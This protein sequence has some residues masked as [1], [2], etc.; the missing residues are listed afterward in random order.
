MYRMY[1]FIERVCD[2]LDENRPTRVFCFTL[3]NL[4]VHA[5]VF[6]LNLITSRGHRYLF[7]APYW[8]VDGPMEYVFNTFHVKLLLFFREIEDLDELRN[9]LNQIIA[10]LSPNGF[11]P[12]FFHVGFPDT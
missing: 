6:I 1:I 8:S 11:D 7:R 2:W 9:A 4:N 5:N 12:Y 3:D 10:Q